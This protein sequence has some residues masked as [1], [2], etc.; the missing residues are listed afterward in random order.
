MRKNRIIQ[1]DS[2]SYK[3]EQSYIDEIS[4]LKEQLIVQKKMS[5]KQEIEISQISEDQKDKIQLLQQ[6]ISR[7][8]ESLQEGESDEHQII[9][10]IEKESSK[11]FSNLISPTEK[12]V[13][14]VNKL[15]MQEDLSIGHEEKGLREFIKEMKQQL[16]LLKRQV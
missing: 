6:Q 1:T 9:D 8:K 14:R 15:L 7:L 3:E 5:M 11:I 10:E 12:I 2:I 13:N 16:C 4:K